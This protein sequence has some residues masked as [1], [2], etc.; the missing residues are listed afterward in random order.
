VKVDD[1]GR[2][3]LRRGIISLARSSC[4]Q[5]KYWMRISRRRRGDT[6]A[7]G[8]RTSP[9]ID[10]AAP[11]AQVQFRTRTADLAR[12][13]AS[14]AVAGSHSGQ[15]LASAPV[16]PPVPPAPPP[17]TGRKPSRHVFRRR[18]SFRRD[19][20][21]KRNRC[22]RKL[23]RP[24]RSPCRWRAGC[25][26]TRR[27]RPIRCRRFHR[28]LLSSC[29]RLFRQLLRHRCA[30]SSAGRVAA[31]AGRR[32][33]GRGGSGRHAVVAGPPVVL[34]C[35]RRRCHP[36]FPSRSCLRR[37]RAGVVAAAVKESCRSDE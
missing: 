24:S 37:G 25:S 6:V 28:A 35:Y 12:G 14:G 5:A 34:R 31:A 32:H 27:R 10:H 11:M 18:A 4:A 2:R 23:R 3:T 15:A 7:T 36:Y 16:P 33:S 29:R 21:C 13:H 22:S 19:R 8:E 30:C 26:D 1:T 17:S 9:T 20:R